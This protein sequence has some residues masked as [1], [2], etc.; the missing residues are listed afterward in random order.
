MRENEGYMEKI[1][2]DKVEFQLKEYRD[3]QWVHKF[4]K[5]FC[6]FDQTGSGCIGLGVENEDK[7]YFVK[8]AGVNTLEAE[9]NPEESV[10]TLKEAVKLYEILR[11]P[12]LINMLE[13]FSMGDMYVVV[14]EWA[15]GECL[16]DHWNFDFYAENPQIKSPSIKYRELPVKKRFD[17]VN[18][19]FSF[20]NLVAKKNYVGVDFYDGSVMY[21]FDTDTTTI[22]DI[23]FFREKPAINDMG[24]DYWGSKRLKAPEEYIL[25]ETIDERTNVFTLG[26]MIFHVFG[27]FTEEQIRMRYKSSCFLPCSIEQWELSKGAY[28]GLLKAV[29]LKPEERYQTVK[30]FQEKWEIL[31]G[32]YR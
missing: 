2:L 25:N 1:T 6:V 21:D 15:K 23:D 3:F 5:V 16:F 8:I 13:H 10:R 17:S 20:L 7:R 19:L 32:E 27:S 29:A 9:L 31:H 18:V 11:H 12:N 26:A 30:E 24:E 28:E 22:C 14:F 4:G